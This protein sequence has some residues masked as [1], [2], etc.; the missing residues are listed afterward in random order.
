MD[1]SP[2]MSEFGVG[3][4]RHIAETELVCEHEL[5]SAKEQIAKD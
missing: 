1:G 4:S 2:Q 3:N 5:G